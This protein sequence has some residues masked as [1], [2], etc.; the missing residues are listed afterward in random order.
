MGRAS[1]ASGG[2]SRRQIGQQRWLVLLH[3]EQVV[4]PAPD[5]LGADLSLGLQRI[6]YHHPPAQ[7]DLGQG[8]L[9]GAQFAAFGARPDLGEH[10]ASP[11]GIHRHQMRAGDPL[12]MHAAQRLAVHCQRFAGCD[13]AA[14]QPVAQ[15]PL[16][17][18]DIELLE[19]PV[20]R[21]D[22]RAAAG[23]Q[24]QFDQQV[25]VIRTALPPPLGHGIHTAA[26]TE[27]GR[28]REL[29]Q[30]DQ[31]MH[32]QMGAAGVGDRRQGLGQRAGRRGGLVHSHLLDRSRTFP[33]GRRAYFP[34]PVPF[35]SG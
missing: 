9:R 30:R 18:R 20:Q 28:H 29:E 7:T 5:N 13:A 26:A 19:H 35:P 21:S 2:K 25:G 33:G 15:R 22:A 24:T 10:R 14:G 11:Q 3:R 17:R 4:A 6:P 31:V 27:E 8:R 1:G 23:S 16:E 32:S 34:A 12:P